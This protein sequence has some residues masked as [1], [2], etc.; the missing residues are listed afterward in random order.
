MDFEKV[1]V[2]LENKQTFQ[3]KTFVIVKFKYPYIAK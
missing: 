1:E 2:L 3:Q